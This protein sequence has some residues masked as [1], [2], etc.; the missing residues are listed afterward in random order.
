MLELRLGQLVNDTDAR[1]SLQM[2]M[3]LMLINGWIPGVEFNSHFVFRW[4]GNSLLHALLYGFKRLIRFLSTSF[5]GQR[6]KLGLGR[7]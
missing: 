1:Y 2:F 3:E 7:R 6:W 5:L 4:H